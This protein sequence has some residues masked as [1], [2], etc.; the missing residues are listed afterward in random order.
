MTDYYGCGL[1]R[2]DEAREIKVKRERR[3]QAGEQRS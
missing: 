1:H 3:E 2:T